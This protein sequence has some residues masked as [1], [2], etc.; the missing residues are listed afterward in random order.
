MCTIAAGKIAGQCSSSS[1][2][3]GSS[4][5][6]H[7][8]CI[9]KRC[10][11][12]PGAGCVSQDGTG[13]ANDFCTTHQQCGSGYCQVTG[14]LRGTCSA[15]NQAIGKPCHASS[16]CTS[17]YCDKGIC[18]QP[19]SPP[20]PAGPTCPSG[21]VFTG[22]YICRAA[23]LCRRYGIISAVRCKRLFLLCVIERV[24]I[25]PVRYGQV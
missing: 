21:Q 20:P 3:L 10:D 25:P 11:N 4:C 14:G 23:G 22:T 9:S 19:G 18:A 8:E 7:N 2:P 15:G 17:K 12:R 5:S 1:K 24:K 13:K 6:T 16:E